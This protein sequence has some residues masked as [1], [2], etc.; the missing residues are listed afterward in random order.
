MSGLE[1]REKGFLPHRFNVPNPQDYVDPY[2]DKKYYGANELRGGVSD[3]VCELVGP[4]TD[5]E[6]FY[7]DVEDKESDLQ[8]ELH[9]HCLSDAL[10][11]RVAYLKFRKDFIVTIGIDLLAR[12]LA[13]KL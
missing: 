10:T 1:E 9:L 7:N 3:A 6:K 11:L 13:S 4:I 2:P 5:F 8:C 12:H